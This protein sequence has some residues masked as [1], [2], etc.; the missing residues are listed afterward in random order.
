MKFNAGDKVVIRSFPGAWKYG[1]GATVASRNGWD[2]YNVS[3]PDTEGVYLFAG[4]E[5]E[6]AH[7]PIK[8]GDS[9]DFKSIPGVA[10]GDF[11]GIVIEIHGA[12]FRVRIDAI[13]SIQELYFPF[14]IDDEFLIVHDS[15]S[16]TPKYDKSLD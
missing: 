4:S 13:Y 9:V 15:V 3:F 16:L 7:T 11:S 10:D 14:S 12:T 6:P 8:I 5:L 1:E 2:G